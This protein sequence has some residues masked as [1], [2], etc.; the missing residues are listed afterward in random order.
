M[1]L[2]KLGIAIALTA[3]AT[4][5][6]VRGIDH[7]E[8]N[9]LYCRSVSQKPQI[10]SVETVCSKKPQPHSQCETVEQTVNRIL[11]DKERYSVLINKVVMQSPAIHKQQSIT[12]LTDNEK[13]ELGKLYL[14]ERLKTGYV[15][16][17]Q[18]VRGLLESGEQKV[19]GW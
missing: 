4:V 18:R 10:S 6:A 11:A 17:S 14:K 3:V 5:V 16:T 13:A 8:L 19:K 2:K 7:F 1:E 15:D 9:E 12:Q